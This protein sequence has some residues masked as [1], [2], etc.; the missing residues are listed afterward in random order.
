[1]YKW[2]F[3]PRLKNNLPLMIRILIVDDD[4]DLLEMVTLMLEAHQ[5]QVKTLNAG[6]FL[7]EALIVETPDVLLM[8]IYLGDSDG[9]ILCHELKTSGKYP[10]LTVFLYSAGDISSQS[11]VESLADS[12]FRK[13]FAMNVLVDS[14]RETVKN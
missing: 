7:D 2:Q 1:M 12:F 8:D 4:E 9:R 5:M 6:R 3:T 10:Q 13:P 14:I 11:I